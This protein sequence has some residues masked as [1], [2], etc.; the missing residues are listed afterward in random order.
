MPALLAERGFGIMLPIP[1]LS[2]ALYPYCRALRRKAHSAKLDD[3]S[4]HDRDNQRFQ[5]EGM[6]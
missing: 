4:S 6:L 2:C 5:A 1:M 3:A